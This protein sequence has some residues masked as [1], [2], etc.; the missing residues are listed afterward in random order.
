M[1]N[2][3]WPWP[4]LTEAHSS[5]CHVSLRVA[6]R[7]WLPGTETPLI[8]SYLSRTGDVLCFSDSIAANFATFSPQNAP[9]LLRRAGSL[10]SSTR[11][12]EEPCVP[13]QGTNCPPLSIP[14]P[15]LKLWLLGNNAPLPFPQ[16]PGACQWPVVM[17][18]GSNVV[19]LPVTSGASRLTHVSQLLRK[20]LNQGSS[21]QCLLPCFQLTHGSHL[22]SVT[23]PAMP[24]TCTAVWEGQSQVQGLWQVNNTVPNSRTSSAISIEYPSRTDLGA[25]ARSG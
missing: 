23:A 25:V 9:L 4:H 3:S 19:P 11:E 21:Q 14:R 6:G 1:N 18:S 15:P 10:L 8:K 22:C 7:T 12:E 13:C 20:A 2:Y 5:V 16:R 17:T 24:A